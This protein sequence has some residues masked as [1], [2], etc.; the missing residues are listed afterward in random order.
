[1][2]AD[3]TKEDIEKQILGSDELTAFFDGKAVRKVIIVPGRIAN[4]VVG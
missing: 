3:A 4:I 2:A 1:M